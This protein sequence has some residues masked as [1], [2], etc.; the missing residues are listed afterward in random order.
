MADM[1]FNETVILTVILSSGHYNVGRYMI[2]VELPITAGHRTLSS[3]LFGVSDKF[4]TYIG[5]DILCI[6]FVY[7]TNGG[8]GTGKFVRPIFKAYRGESIV[9]EN[10]CINCYCCNIGFFFLHTVMTVLEE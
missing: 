6:V 5:L 3:H 1:C 2:K 7:Y 4:Y 9:M 8:G 10:E